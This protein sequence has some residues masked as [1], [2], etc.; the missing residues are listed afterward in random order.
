LL[1]LG[2]FLLLLPTLLLLLP[3][4]LLLLTVLGRPIAAAIL[5]PALT[6]QHSMPAPQHSTSQSDLIKH[7]TQY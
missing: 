7:N 2:M 6:Q 5:R 1:L 3:T 4:L